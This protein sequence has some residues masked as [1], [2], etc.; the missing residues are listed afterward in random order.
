MMLDN[1]A[2]EYRVGGSL[3][4]H[5]PSYV[6]READQSFYYGLKSGNFCYVFNSRQMGKTSLLVRTLHRLRSEGVSCTTIDVS[7]RGSGDIQPEQ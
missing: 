1:K 3:P 4:E 5:A 6:T 7:G 2:Y